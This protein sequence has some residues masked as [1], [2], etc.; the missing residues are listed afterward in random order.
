MLLRRIELKPCVL[1]IYASIISV[2][3]V[4]VKDIEK[5]GQTFGAI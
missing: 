5:I 4:E 3:N 2:V 1:N